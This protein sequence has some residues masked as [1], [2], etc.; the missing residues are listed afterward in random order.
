M[1]GVGGAAVG[2]GAFG[3]AAVGDAVVKDGALGDAGDGDA[4][5]VVA[6]ES[7]VVVAGRLVS[8]STPGAESSSSPVGGPGRKMPNTTDTTIATPM[9][10]S[11]TS[12]LTAPL[13]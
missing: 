13:R 9:T 12:T 11:P 2:D 10:P 3:D 7:A 5:G 4:V 1:A 8:S 6:T